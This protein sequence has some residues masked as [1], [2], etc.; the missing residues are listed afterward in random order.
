[1]QVSR[2]QLI[3]VENVECGVRF[4]L[5]RRRLTRLQQCGRIEIAGCVIRIGRAARVDVRVECAGRNQRDARAGGGDL[6]EPCRISVG[7]EGLGPENLDDVEVLENL[8]EIEHLNCDVERR[9]QL[10]LVV[11]RHD[12]RHQLD[13]RRRRR[14][15]RDCGFSWPSRQI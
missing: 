15:F 9:H 5:A 7:I 10:V 2:L 8:F 11:L 6:D 12:F 13:D 3:D 1:M 14:R 4:A